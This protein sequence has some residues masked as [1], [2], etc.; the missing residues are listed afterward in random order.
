MAHVENI[1]RGKMFV[2]SVDSGISSGEKE[3]VDLI[4]AQENLGTVA[5]CAAMN[6]GERYDSYHVATHDANYLLRISLEN[7]PIFDGENKILT[8]FSDNVVNI[9]PKLVSCNTLDIHSHPVQ[10]QIISFE[11]A[12]SAEEM[13]GSA[14]LINHRPFLQT[15]KTLHGEKVSAPTFSDRLKQ[16]FADTDFSANPEFEELVKQNSENYQLLN[17][18][19]SAAK[20]HV[21]DSFKPHFEEDKLIH[22]NLSNKN[23]LFGED[24][25]KIVSWADACLA[26]PLIELARLKFSLYLDQSIEHKFFHEYNNLA[27]GKYSWEEYVQI[28]DFIAA[29]ELLEGVYSYV[30]EIFLYGGKRQKHMLEIFS[31][32]CK[33]SKHFDV[34]PAFRKNKNEIV[35]LF[36][37]PML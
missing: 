5:F 18:E 23:I 36:S 21:Q 20:Q 13:G 6:H 34:I 11:R 3:F 35:K 7:S 9:V 31:R 1:L 26:N 32:F 25:F 4:F 33:N 30:K 17:D 29:I 19:L 2:S 27:G 10:Y 15:L 24:S 14:I 16:I 8:Q 22:F 37:A 28:R 12:K